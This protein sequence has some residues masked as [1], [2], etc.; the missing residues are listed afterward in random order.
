MSTNATEEDRK[1][2]NKVLKLF[3]DFFQV[4]RNIKFE[5][6][7]FNRRNQL[8]GESSEQYI[9][10]LYTLASNCNYGTFEHE[11]ILDRLVV[12]IRD[13]ALSKRLQLDAELTLKKPKKLSVGEKQYR[14]SRASS[15]EQIA[16]ALILSIRKTTEGDRVTTEI[17]SIEATELITNME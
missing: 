10:L 13:T 2:H 12:G 17:L 15:V 5:R 4:P 3:D 8:P 6:A 1:D 14:S 11:M 16:P 7:R 9:T